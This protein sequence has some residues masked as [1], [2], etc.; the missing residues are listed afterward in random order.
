MYR[1]LASFAECELWLEYGVLVD[2]PL[3]DE[4]RAF[5]LAFRVSPLWNAWRLE[6]R[7]DNPFC[8]ECLRERQAE[9]RGRYGSHRSAKQGRRVRITESSVFV[10]FMP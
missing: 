1:N 10:R 6:W 3:D 8:E 4:K 2:G 5:I 7:E 9:V